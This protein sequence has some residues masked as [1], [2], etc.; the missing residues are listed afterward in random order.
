MK[1]EK[2]LKKTAAYLNNLD[3]AKRLSVAVGLPIEKAGGHL[4]KTGESLIE[5]GASHEYG[6][7]VPLRSFLRMPFDV[8]KDVISKEIDIQFKKVLLENRSAK[9]ALGFI[10]VAARNI[11]IDA[12][13]TGGFGQWPDITVMTKKLKKSS[14]ILIDT[15]ILR[16]AITWVVR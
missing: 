16:G 9:R 14:K 2:F 6:A 11:V 15:G 4:Y 1:P 5:V 13:R 10:G 8:K 7:G 12:F 3:D